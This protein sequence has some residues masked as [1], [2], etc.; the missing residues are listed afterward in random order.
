MH[1]DKMKITI[2]PSGG[3]FLFLIL[4]LS[5]GIL[6]SCQNKTEKKEMSEK[7]LYIYEKDLERSVFEDRWSVDLIN[8]KLFGATS[9]F[10]IGIAEYHLEDFRLM[11]IHDDQE[12]VYIL[13]GEGEYKLGDETFPVSPGCAVY[14]PPKTRHCVRRTTDEPVRLMYGHAA[15]GDIP[16]ENE[17]KENKKHFVCN[18]KIERK[19]TE[20]HWGKAIINNEFFDVTGG[21]SLG[22]SV[23]MAKEFSKQPGSHEDQESIYILSGEGEYMLGDNIFPISPG[24]AIL[25][26]P[27]TKHAIRCTTDEPVRLIY[28]HGAN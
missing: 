4:L 18:E 14:V 11:G 21:C 2:K 9:G 10:S 6:I 13:S 16:A 27:K 28:T 20:L 23:T 15:I 7:R 17:K 8:S 22:M 24:C 3:K 26:P 5:A 25:V 12:V 19:G 1:T